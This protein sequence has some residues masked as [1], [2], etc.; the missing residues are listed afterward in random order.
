MLVYNVYTFKMSYDT[1]LL[2][3]EFLYCLVNIQY[4]Q[5]TEE[6]M[7]KVG[8]MLLVIFL[9]KFNWIILIL[10]S[11][12]IKR[13][14]L[15]SLSS[16]CFFVG[17]VLLDLM[18]F[19]AKS[20]TTKIPNSMENSNWNVP[21]QMQGY[22]IFLIILQSVFIKSSL[23]FFYSPNHNCHT[24]NIWQD[25]I[26]KIWRNL[27]MLIFGKFVPW[28]NQKDVMKRFIIHLYFWF[29]SLQCPKPK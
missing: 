9:S 29:C 10:L 11:K 1:R 28:K 26:G 14:S 23:S 22:V 24:W 16:P 4:S 15:R 18:F 5:H 21:Y 12:R 6:I 8:G 25:I 3:Q 7:L 2:K 20:K 17:F 13:L 27:E 19:Y